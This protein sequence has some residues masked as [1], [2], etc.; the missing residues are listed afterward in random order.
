MS[1]YGAIVG[2]VHERLLREPVGSISLIV[3]HVVASEMCRRLTL[4]Q[5][6]LA[7]CLKLD[8][9]IFVACVRLKQVFDIAAEHAGKGDNF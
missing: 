4:C 6:R 5:Q 8:Q 2:E 1:F 9:R 7:D 3:A